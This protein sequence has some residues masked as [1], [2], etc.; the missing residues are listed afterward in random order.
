MKPF[1]EYTIKEV[2]AMGYKV[3]LEGPVTG[4]K[5]TGVMLHISDSSEKPKSKLSPTIRHGY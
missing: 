5:S 1:E 4:K 3:T 2:V